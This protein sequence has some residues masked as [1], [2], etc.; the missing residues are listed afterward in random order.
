MSTKQYKTGYVTDP[1]EIEICLVNEHQAEGEDLYDK[2]MDALIALMHQLALRHAREKND[3]AA[4]HAAEWSKIDQM[5][6]EERESP[7]P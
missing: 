3:T 6:Q 1:Q 7:T 4:R 5:I 2:R